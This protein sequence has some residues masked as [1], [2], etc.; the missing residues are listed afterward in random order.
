MEKT[1]RFFVVLQDLMR[2]NQIP[3]YADHKIA[4]Q[5]DS[6]GPFS[7]ISLYQSCERT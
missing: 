7:A 2:E 1:T 3:L 4:S 5:P 6:E